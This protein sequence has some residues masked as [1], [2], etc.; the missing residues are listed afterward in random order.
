MA[1]ATVHGM[2]TCAGR[3]RGGGRE[4][5]RAETITV[6]EVRRAAACGRE[7]HRRHWLRRKKTGKKEKKP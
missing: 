3:V 2:C 6:V 7:D 4:G 1:P 5:R